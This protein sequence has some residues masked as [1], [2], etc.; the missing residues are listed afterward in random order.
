MDQN[1]ALPIGHPL[2]MLGFTAPGQAQGERIHYRFRPL[3]SEEGEGRKNPP[4]RGRIGLNHPDRVCTHPLSRALVN[5]S[6]GSLKAGIADERQDDT[7]MHGGLG[8]IEIMQPIKVW[9]RTGQSTT[10]QKH[11]AE[12]DDENIKAVCISFHLCLP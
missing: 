4:E 12:H 1:L 11:Y 7:K 5:F 2:V 9:G 6:T 3:R 8:P 10:G